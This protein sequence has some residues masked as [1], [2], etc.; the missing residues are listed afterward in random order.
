MIVDLIIKYRLLLAM[1]GQL[2]QLF[3]FFRSFYCLQVPLFFSQHSSSKAL[4]VIFSFVGT[5]WGGPFVGPFFCASL[6]L[7]FMLF[8]EVF[9]SCLFS[10][11]ANDTHIFSPTHVILPLIILFPSW[12]LWGCS[13]NFASARPRLHLAYLL[14]NSYCPFNGIPF[15]FAS[16]TSSFL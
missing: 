11:L 8:F 14:S 1:G 2:S 3:F 12:L 10:S 16:F 5:C 7:C 6:V 13:F 9:L 4:S 15:G